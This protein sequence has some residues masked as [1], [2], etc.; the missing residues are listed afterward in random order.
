M[1]L[2]ITDKAKEDLRYWKKS[3]NLPIQKKISQILESIQK[4]PFEG[5]GKPEPL[6]YELSG[7]W[8][9]RINKEHRVVYEVAENKIVI[10]SLLGHY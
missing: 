1:E 8:S 4:T 6:K 3:G 5:Q 2:V 9:R 7:T 10:H